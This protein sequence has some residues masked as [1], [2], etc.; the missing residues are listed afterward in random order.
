MFDPCK[1]VLDD[2]KKLREGTNEKRCDGNDTMS[3]G[4]GR[5]QVAMQYKEMNEK[6]MSIR[7]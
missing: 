4:C 2:V 6:G 1:G 7:A 3:R 5:K